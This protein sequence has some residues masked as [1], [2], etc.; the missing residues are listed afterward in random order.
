MKMTIRTRNKG[1]HVTSEG[2]KPYQWESI[3]PMGESGY[4]S[5]KAMQKE[6]K[7][8]FPNDKKRHVRSRRIKNGLVRIEGPRNHRMTQVI[9]LT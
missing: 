3:T 1:R 2:V 5:V 6:L 8:R 4:E 9:T 7:C